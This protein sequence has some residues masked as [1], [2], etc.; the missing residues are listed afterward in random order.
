MNTEGG[1]SLAA[2]TA[3]L[4]AQVKQGNITRADYNTTALTAAAAFGRVRDSV[5]GVPR[6]HTT[7]IRTSGIPTARQQ[8]LG[9]QSYLGM[10]P[11]S[12]TTVLNVLTN[13]LPGLGGLNIPGRAG[14]GDVSRNRL[15]EVAEQ[16]RT[17]LLRMGGRT[18]LIPGSDGVVDPATTGSTGGAGGA[19][20]TLRL[21]IE[22][23]GIL[24][25]LRK[26]CEVSAGG[27]AQ[28]FIGTG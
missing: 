9:F 15:Y 1:P 16:G 22:G 28:V 27:S 14:G 18:Y 2:V 25:G 17:E 5:N 7:D 6:Q 26:E 3:Q 11:R 23:T 8:I 19:G 13:N 20:G 21:I 24:E 12:I 4:K 10:I